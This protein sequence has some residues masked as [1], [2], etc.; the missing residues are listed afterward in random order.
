MWAAEK[1]KW[2]LTGSSQRGQKGPIFSQVYFLFLSKD[3]LGS[4]DRSSLKR[5]A[6]RQGITKKCHLS[7][8]TNSG[9]HI[10]VQKG[11]R[12]ELRG[13]SQ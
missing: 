6:R 10:R 4:F 7:L 1:M 13:L 8:L 9:P 12:G 5:E 2:F 11:G 3:R